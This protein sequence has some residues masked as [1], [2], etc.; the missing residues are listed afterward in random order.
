MVGVALREALL[1]V[2]E[3]KTKRPPM[4]DGNDG[5][6]AYPP[7]GWTYPHPSSPPPLLA[8]FTSESIQAWNCSGV[9]IVTY[10]RIR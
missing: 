6:L 1:A 10:P 3:P 5:R 7:S 9:S 2:N 8:F 4:P